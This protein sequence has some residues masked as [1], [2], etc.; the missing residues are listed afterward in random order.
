MMKS[1]EG[2]AAI[3]QQA[4]ETLL[5]TIENHEDLT[6][7][8]DVIFGQ[9]MKIGNMQLPAV[10]VTPSP[11]TPKIIGGHR[12]QH[13]MPFDIV[14]LVKEF[15]PEKGL[16]KA[17][18]IVLSIYDVLMK[19]RTQGGSVSDT[20]PTRVDPT[21]EAGNSTQVYWSSIQMTFRIQKKE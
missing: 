19:D 10:W 12:T 16:K 2:I 7:I 6:E 4:R 11:Y 18:E 3:Y 8:Q 17:Q 1:S 9:K 15:E 21:Y 14:V 20:L 5:D 13:D